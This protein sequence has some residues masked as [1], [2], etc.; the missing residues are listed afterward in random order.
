MTSA[1]DVL[2]EAIKEG[3]DSTEASQI[4]QKALDESKRGKYPEKSVFIFP[5]FAS[6]LKPT[7]NLRE[8]K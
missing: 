8:P 1:F 4:F 6:G 3:K 2:R 7:E 5:G